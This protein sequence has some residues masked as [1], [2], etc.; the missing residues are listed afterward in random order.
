VRLA[1]SERHALEFI[2]N[3]V[4]FTIEMQFAARMRPFK[5]FL[6][7]YSGNHPSGGLFA[8]IRA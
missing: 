2:S 6:C 1:V 4:R 8:R 5:G 3:R 7:F